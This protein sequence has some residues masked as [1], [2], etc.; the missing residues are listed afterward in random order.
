[1]LNFASISISIAQSTNS[2]LQFQ[3]G[4]KVS[5]YSDKAYRKAGGK[6]FE[7]V[8]N[9]IVL[10]G[11]DTLYGERA[12]FDIDK[13][14]VLI[15]GSVRYIGEGITV[16]GSMIKF[17]MKTS[18]LSIANARVITPEFSIVANLIKKESKDRYYAEEAEFTTCKD[19][20]ESWV[21]SGKKIYIQLK[22][23]V[24]IHHVFAKVKGVDVLYLPYIALPI[25]DERESGL[26]F[27]KIS[28]RADEGVYYE[29][30]LFLALGDSKD[31]TISPTFLGERGYGLNL[32]YRQAFSEKS[33]LEFNNKMA[34]DKI[35]FPRSERTSSEYFRH[36]FEIE[37]HSQWTNSLSHHLRITGAKDS[38]FF[39]DY[40]DYTTDYLN[41]VD[42]G[43]DLFIDKRFDQFSLGVEAYFKK[44][45]ITSDSEE[46]D[47]FYVQS[48][49]SISFSL[50]PQ[51]LLQEKR[52]YFYKLSTG[53]DGDVTVFKQQQR[54]EDLYLRN[55][56]RTNVSPYLKLNILNKGPVS[57]STTYTLDYQ[58]YR[59]EDREE[60]NFY[61][62]A[63]FVST[64]VSFSLEKI[65]G[66]AYSE[67]YTS[68]ELGENSFQ[69]LL[70]TS[71]QEEQQKI[72]DDIIGDLKV[73]ENS[74]AQKSV[75]VVRNSYR[76]SQEFKFIHHQ[77]VS[78]G[79][80][81]NTNFL[82]QIET[83]DG[84]FDYLDAI[85]ANQE[86]IE[87]NETRQSIPLKNTLELQWNNALIKK[88]PKTFNYLYD[89]R[90]LKDN[91]TY[92]KM[93]HFNV[94][95]GFLL[96][97]SGSYFEDKLTRLFVDSAYSSG[98][99]N[100]TLKDY[101]FHQAGDHILGLTTEKQFEQINLLGT[102][103][104]NSFPNSS[105]KTLKVGFQLRPFDT[106]GFSYLTEEDLD[107]NENIASIYQVD[108]MPNNNCWIFIIN[109]KESFS[110]EREKRIGFNFEF[111]F[112]NDEFKNY[113]RNFF[114][115]NRLGLR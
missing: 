91:F 74:L 85:R 2:P 34:M 56:V 20:K 10:S 15:E 82:S 102:Y 46:F 3:L 22:Q 49:P 26:L 16:Y 63:G 84:W 77:I 71:D 70:G 115:F 28:S 61:K 9:V 33:W 29:Q 38:D 98:N 53:I 32:E 17:D 67:S 99:W 109:Y 76:H 51:V 106:F 81:G 68:D 6:H 104:L 101:Y 72:S 66:L 31:T 39:R 95:Q 48:L 50:M 57:L 25:K 86:E 58:E 13:G 107:A 75:N 27:P 105:L 5:I 52:D 110:A 64:E 59:F 19:C 113:K 54:Q 90:Y 42:V 93:G 97:G 92:R 1:M 96:D 79:E 73:F 62:H 100:F 7:A 80:N 30:P 40:V 43:A 12:S 8:G 88:T 112:G 24:Q 60:S 87:S 111:N 35:Y 14:E 44:N 11:A 4:D 47:P 103:N 89:N 36:F 94:S 108:F 114:S 78:S 37:N 55:V 18:K 65:F 69:K 21:L 83:E 23:Y 41:T 45:I